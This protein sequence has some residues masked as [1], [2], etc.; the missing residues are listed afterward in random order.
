[1]LYLPLLKAN[2][3]VKILPYICISKLKFRPEFFY[4]RQL[5]LEVLY[6]FTPLQNKEEKYYI[7]PTLL[8]QCTINF[9]ISSNVMLVMH[10]KLCDT[11]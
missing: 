2:V 6:Y 9:A 3:V 5:I 8:G 1:M 11:W 7:L 4:L 10:V